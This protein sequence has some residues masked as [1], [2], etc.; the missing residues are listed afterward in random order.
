MYID[1]DTK[2][3]VNVHAPYKQFSKLNTPEIRAAANVVEIPD[4]E[5]KNDA[6]YYVT[7]TNE[8]PYVI[9]TEKPLEQVV[10]PVWEKIKAH[11]DSLTQNGGC[12]VGT[13]WFHSDTHSKLQQLSLL[14][15]GA[16]MPVGLEWKT[17]DGTF[18]QMNPE[19]AQ[20][21]FAAQVAQEQGIFTVAEQK[22]LALVQLATVDEVAAFK[23][24]TG[25]PEVYVEA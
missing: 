12:K 18:I 10:P 11:R 6:Y 5:R 21:V 3:R 14:T 7:E 16:A 4:P 2:Q 8:P 23:W 15:M 24:D 20:A 22:R 19:L 25:W 17:M 1:N 13:K 9:N